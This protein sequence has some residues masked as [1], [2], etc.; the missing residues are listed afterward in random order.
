MAQHPSRADRWE[1]GGSAGTSVGLSGGLPPCPSSQLTEQS[2][3]SPFRLDGDR[4]GH[5][6]ALGQLSCPS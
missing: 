6:G 5:V 3:P 2:G 4:P 1:K